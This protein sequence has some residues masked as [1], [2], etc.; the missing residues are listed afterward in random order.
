MNPK[1]GP[2]TL[3][4][5]PEARNR[6][7]DF[8]SDVGSSLWG[9]LCPPSLGPTCCLW[10]CAMGDMTVQRR[11]ERRPPSPRAERKLCG[12]IPNTDPTFA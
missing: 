3:E 5:N 4:A 9:L 7:L 10:A 8:A 11:S 12:V 6:I 1:C 2:K